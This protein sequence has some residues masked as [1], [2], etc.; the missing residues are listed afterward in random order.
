M[1]CGW[2]PT[3]VRTSAEMELEQ[4]AELGCGEPGMTAC[5]RWARRNPGH[6]PNRNGQS[7]EYT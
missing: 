6:F 1:E 3:C 2:G 5:D 4:G 7:C